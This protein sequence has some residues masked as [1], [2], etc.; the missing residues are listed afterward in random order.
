VQKKGGASSK[1]RPSRM[2]VLIRIGTR[3]KPFNKIEHADETDRAISISYSPDF[4]QSRNL[5][6]IG[7]GMARITVM[8][9]YQIRLT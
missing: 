7:S 4:D 6:K 5:L 8:S 9:G 1:P 3:K 2:Q